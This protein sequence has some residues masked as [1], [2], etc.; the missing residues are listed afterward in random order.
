MELDYLKGHMGNNVII[1]IYGDQVPE[2][3][4]VGIALELLEPN[5]VSG[6]E[7]GIL[8]PPKQGGD[9]KTK[10]VGFTTRDFITAC[11][12]LTQVLGKAMVENHLKEPFR[13]PVQGPKTKILL[14]TDSGLTEITVEMEGGKGL[15]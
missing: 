8:Y 13:L 7:V 3:K 1:F 14:E 5:R 6:H 10:I 15:D 11:G 2:G 12:G 9:L 4:E